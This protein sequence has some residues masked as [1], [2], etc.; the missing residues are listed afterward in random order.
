MFTSELW[1]IVAGQSFAQQS[2][3]SMTLGATGSQQSEMQ[4]LPPQ[5]P[6][7]R[8][9]PTPPA[10]TCG[11]DSRQFC[12]ATWPVELL[13]AIPR[14]P[15][16]ATLIISDTDPQPASPH[17]FTTCG[18]YCSAASDCGPG[19]TEDEC[20]CAIPSPQDA[21]TLGLDPV[22]P[23]SVCLVLA[24]AITGLSGRDGGRGYLDER[25]EAYQCRCNATYVSNECCGAKD[26]IVWLP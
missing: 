11:F 21:R 7:N 12:P 15:P 17:N 8:L 2:D 20:F 18:Q 23:V 1:N 6:S 3:G 16:N 4:I 24:L 19:D 25:G 13:G 26:G 14:A 10:G 9:S 22:A 5:P